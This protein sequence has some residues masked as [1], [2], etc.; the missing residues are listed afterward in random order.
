MRLRINLL[1]NYL[2]GF[3]MVPNILAACGLVL[4]LLFWAAFPLSLHAIDRTPGFWI[5]WG[6]IGTVL[7][8]APII[9]YLRRK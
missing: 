8:G 3:G 4:M 2:F 6:A 9:L 1:S 7:I 5:G